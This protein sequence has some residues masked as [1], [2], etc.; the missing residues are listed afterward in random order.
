MEAGDEAILEIEDFTCASPWEQFVADA[1]AVLRGWGLGRQ[2]E[3]QGGQGGTAA[4]LEPGVR[5]SWLRFAPAPGQSPAEFLLNFRCCC[6]GKD[7]FHENRCNQSMPKR[8][9]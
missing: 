5:E 7:P 8:P 9:V 1:E 3:C 4:A 6:V 2:P